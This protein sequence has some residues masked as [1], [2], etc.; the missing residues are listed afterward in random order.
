MPP[1]YP[2][3]CPLELRPSSHCLL[4]PC[5]EARSWEQACSWATLAPCHLWGEGPV[6]PS[7]RRIRGFPPLLLFGNQGPRFGN[8]WEIGSSGQWVPSLLFEG[9]LSGSRTSLCWD[10]PKLPW[11]QF[12][13][14][15]QKDPCKALDSRACAW[16][17]RGQFPLASRSFLY[18]ELGLGELPASG[19][20]SHHAGKWEEGFR[21]GRAE[22]RLPAAQ[23]FTEVAS[24]LCLLPPGQIPG[25]PLGVLEFTVST[26]LPPPR[27]W[28]G[29]ISRALANPRGSGWLTDWHLGLTSG[30]WHLLPVWGTQGAPAAAA[31]LPVTA[32][33]WEAGPGVGTLTPAA[34]SKAEGLVLIPTHYTSRS[35][36]FLI[37]L[38]GL[39][40][41]RNPAF[42]SASLET[43]RRKYSCDGERWV[44]VR[45]SQTLEV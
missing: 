37:R 28:E 41:A 19:G 22:I 14:H 35:P 26:G 21:P 2:E 13:C 32:P 34:W 38:P 24:Q 18:L 20:I 42:P 40:P 15:W 4:S 1:L 25:R 29:A 3:P 5:K 16:G 17:L 12:S 45:I 44:R 27:V 39:L 23:I 8:E 7:S 30:R 6:L 43:E 36:V 11:C 31:T 9:S 10:V 33:W